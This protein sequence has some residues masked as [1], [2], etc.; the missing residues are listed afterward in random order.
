MKENLLS[1]FKQHIDLSEQDIELITKLDLIRSYKKGTIFLKEGEYAKHCFFV[2]KGCI[3]SY[4][5]LDG[6]E[7]TTEFFTE[8]QPITPV[9]YSLKQP[10]Q[11]F[12][13][14]IED[15][16]IS[17]GSDETTA[18]IKNQ[19]PKMESLISKF[20]EQLFVDSQIK[21]ENYF[22][23]SPQE[24]YLKLF[25]ERPDLCQRVP[26]YLLASY[27]GIKPQSLSRIRKRLAK[28]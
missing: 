16:V 15:C 6:E 23:L 14:C 13:S 26:Q 27:L 12:L 11:Y 19:I 22:T 20:N 24:R 7:K 25:K 28:E 8:G 2:I 4:Y 18:L 21:F 9:S 10:S 1:F 3:R 5:L 17:A